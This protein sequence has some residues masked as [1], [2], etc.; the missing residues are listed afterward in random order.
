MTPLSRAAKLL[1]KDAETLEHLALAQMQAGFG[2]DA[3]RNFER[4]LGLEPDRLGALVSAA[5]LA[6]R[7]GNFQ[8]AEKYCRRALRL[9]ANQPEALFNLGLAMKGLGRK[10]EA[11]AALNNAASL[12]T[13]SGMAQNDIGLQ[14]L[15]LGMV[16]EAECCFRRA[17]VLA[18]GNAMAHSNLGRALQIRGL[19]GDAL[20]ALRRAVELAPELAVTH[21]NLAGAYNAVNR[22]LESEAASRQAIRLDPSQ[23]GALCNLGNAL[24]GQRRYGEA[25]ACYRDALA[26][27]PGYADA[28]NNLGNLL[29]VL[30]RYDEALPCF[31]TIRDDRG[32]AL[33]KAFH[34]A[35]QICDWGQRGK[36]EAALRLRLKQPDTYIDPFDFLALPAPDAA[37]LQMRLGHLAATNHFGLG[38]LEQAP[39]AEPS[40]RPA[41]DRLRI[42]Y[43]SADFHDH[44]TMHLIA[45][46][47]AAHDRSR[48]AI[49]LYSYGPDADD[50]YR[51][52]ARESA[53]VFRDIR[54]LT[55]ADAA[56]QIAN[57]GV[58]ILIELKG[59][60]Q[61]GRLGIAARRPAPVIVSWLGYPGTLGHPR[62]ADYIIGDPVVTPFAAAGQFAETIVQMPHCYQPNDRNRPIGDQPT[63]VAAGLPET[64]FVFCSFNQSFKFNPETADVWARLLKAVPGS[65]LWLLA[66]GQT[67]EENLRREFGHRGVAGSSI[68]FAPVLPLPQHLGRL[69]LADLA[70]DTFPVSSH[71]TG[72]DALWAGVPM[73][74]LAGNTFAGRVGASLLQA[75]G[76]PEM[77]TDDWD[78]YF[79]LARELALEPVRLGPLRQR[80]AQQ[81]L[82]APLFD[83]LR[84]ARDLEAVYQ[85]LWV[86]GA[87]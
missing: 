64:G 53:D 40:S 67:A 56:A 52:Q 5:S 28:R 87:G 73:L 43:L 78:A 61:D 41:R 70:L 80:L 12:T 47:L 62:L 75:V 6:N 17:I 9:T 31:R 49:H 48:H 44:A 79:A 82:Q 35:A 57:D 2:K 37:E 18:P 26:I 50:A 83:T 11:A 13:G 34:C 15:D 77:V 55:D 24:M 45:G 39:L 86:A 58:D 20:A 8:T 7:Q 36:D 16:T 22:Y 84:F 76:L 38:L 71:T 74:T 65:V 60:T 81:R 25:E 29:Q 72:S 21:A 46:V 66:V 10:A 54:K 27:D 51:R 69:P 23:P 59:Y 68:V 33:G 1:P 19:D 4:C 42:G 32:Y 3:L 63:R 14:L 30:R 85:R